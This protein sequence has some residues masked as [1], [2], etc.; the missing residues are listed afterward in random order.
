MANFFKD[1]MQPAKV[2]FDRLQQQ[3]DKRIIINGNNGSTNGGTV[4]PPQY[5]DLPEYPCEIIRDING[6]VSE[7]RYGRNS[8]GY[9]WRQ[10]MVRDPNGKLDHIRQDNPDGSFA[11]VLDRNINTGKVDMIDIQ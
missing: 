1:F 5:V 2:I 10:V 7:V 4:I 9:I 3:K 6:K 11:I 8:R